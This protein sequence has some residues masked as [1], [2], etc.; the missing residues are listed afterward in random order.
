[1]AQLAT[2]VEA[3]YHALIEGMKNVQ[4]VDLDLT[5]AGVQCVNSRR[6]ITI[7][8]NGIRGPFLRILHKR[9][10]RENL[11]KV[12]NV[13]KGAHTVL[14]LE[15]EAKEA[16]AGGRFER[17]VTAA[18]DAKLAIDS[19][20]LKNVN[21]MV[22]ASG[23]SAG[24]VHLLLKEL[25]VAIPFFPLLSFLGWRESVIGQVVARAPFGSRQEP[26]KAV[27]W[28]DQEQY[29]LHRLLLRRVLV[30]S[31][32]LHCKCGGY[33]VIVALSPSDFFFQSKV[34]I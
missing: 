26:P 18:T 32:G 33:F 13:V 2:R 31:Q 17:A 10:R 9:I 8:D 12:A 19:E 28:Q 11:Q 20:L 3:N 25:I 29:C 23:M 21:M 16:A 22:R 34:K 7:A 1:M 5:T 27:Q 15:K 30:D 14:L 4:E 24:H 6:K